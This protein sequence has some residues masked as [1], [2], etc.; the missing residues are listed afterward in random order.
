VTHVHLVYAHPSDRSFTREL[1]DAF[2]GGLGEAGH[3][4]TVS[5]LYAMGFRA[6][7]SAEEYERESGRGG[8]APVAD[9]VLAEQ[10]RLDAAD[11]WVFVYPV[12]WADCPARLKG[13]FDRVWTVGFAYKTPSVRAADKALVLCAAG[14]T[15]AELNE[16]G[17]HQAMRT[18]ML[19]DRIGERARSGEFV[20][21]GGSVLANDP[22]AAERWAAVKAG[23]LAQAAALAR[24]V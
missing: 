21:F 7:L 10:A 20:V 3:T 17:C 19:T 16:S 9:D 11:V 24:S 22:G 6:E 12:W 5:D 13:W 18:I 8:A 14:Y 1:L 2:V 23:H 4:Y 15:V